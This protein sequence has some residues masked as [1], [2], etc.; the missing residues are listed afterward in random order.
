LGGIDQQTR[1][2]KLQDKINKLVRV[3]INDNDEQVSRHY[4]QLLTAIEYN[5]VCFNVENTLAEITG[6]CSFDII[7]DKHLGDGE[8]VVVLIQLVKMG[9]QYIDWYC[10]Y[11]NQN[12][13]AMVW[14]YRLSKIAFYFCTKKNFS[15][16]LNTVEIFTGIFK[17]ESHLSTFG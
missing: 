12:E 11:W 2:R 7:V 3:G 15:T 14:N 9:I 10:C 17:I 13:K 8:R 4:K 6:S 5:N 16:T 1:D